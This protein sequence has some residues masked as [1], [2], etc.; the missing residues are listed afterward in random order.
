MATW[1]NPPPPDRSDPAAVDEW[2]EVEPE[3]KTY[4]D[5]TLSVEWEEL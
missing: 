5:G 3:M 1:I 4:I 2:L